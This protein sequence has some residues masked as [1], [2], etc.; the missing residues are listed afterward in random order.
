V[1]FEKKPQSYHG[2]LLIGRSAS[3]RERNIE[4]SSKLCGNGIWIEAT[5][6]DNLITSNTAFA[7]GG[8]A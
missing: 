3:Y 7:K 8:S 1:K 5:A 4:L 6:A 2:L